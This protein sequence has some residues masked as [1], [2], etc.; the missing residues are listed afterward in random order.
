[1][2]RELVFA[3]LDGLAEAWLAARPKPVPVR[4]RATATE[5]KK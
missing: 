5:G 1:M 4:V 3:F 2:I